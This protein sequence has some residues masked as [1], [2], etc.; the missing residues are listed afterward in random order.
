MG[1]LNDHF[2]YIIITSMGGQTILKSSK[3]RSQVKGAIAGGRQ[4]YSMPPTLKVIELSGFPGLLFPCVTKLMFFLL[5]M[6]ARKRL[7]SEKYPYSAMDGRIHGVA[8]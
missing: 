6:M 2:Q 5:S 3:I 7:E 8:Q 1:N 4:R